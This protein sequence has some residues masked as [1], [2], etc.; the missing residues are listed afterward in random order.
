MDLKQ[1]AG[2]AG[3]QYVESGMIVGLGTGSTA[4]FA[5]KKLSE[6]IKKEGLSIKAIPTSRS[7]EI[8]ATE[9]NIPLLSTG[10]VNEVD[11]TID[12]A[13]EIDKKY[14]MIK[15]GGGAL[16]R[17]K[18]IASITRKEIIVVEPKKVVPKL[19]IKFALPVEVV[20][21][22][23]EITQKRIAR[24]E[25]VPRLQIQDG[26]PYITDNGNYILNCKF[27]GIEIPEKLESELNNIP[28]VVA[29]GLFIGLAHMLVIGD[30]KGAITKTKRT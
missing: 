19:G 12:G 20:K 13:D 28:G 15:G 16:L 30:V 5:I 25:C 8:I 7:S 24:L 29:N 17:E 27:D 26:K 21:F 9:L 14:R 4:Y 1:I 22:G 11:I 23:W 2:E 3:A 18:M 6:R 10:E